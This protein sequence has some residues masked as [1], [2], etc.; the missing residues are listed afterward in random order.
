MSE[1]CD[2]IEVVSHM[3]VSRPAASVAAP[4]AVAEKLTDASKPQGRS[5]TAAGTSSAASRAARTSSPS[6]A[7]SSPATR[8]SPSPETSPGRAWYAQSPRHATVFVQAVDASRGAAS[9]AT[10]ST[11]TPTLPPP[12]SSARAPASRTTTSTDS[13]TRLANARQ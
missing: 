8:A 11:P 13:A 5:T 12:G 10:S 9:T 4:P 3:F 6:R 1:S 2:T 7:A